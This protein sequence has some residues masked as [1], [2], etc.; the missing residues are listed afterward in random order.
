MHQIAKICTYIFKKIS[1]GDI[2]GPHTWY[3]AS[4]L[5]RS[6]PLVARSPSH[7]LQSFCGRCPAVQLTLVGCAFIRQQNAQTD[8]VCGFLSIRLGELKQMKPTMSFDSIYCVHTANGMCKSLAKNVAPTQLC[9]R[10]T[11][12]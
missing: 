8:T 2:P 7:F 9:R 3:A 12:C 10:L 6:L 1:G 4:P 5:P 11:G